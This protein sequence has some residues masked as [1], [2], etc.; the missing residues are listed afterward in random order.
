MATS[1]KRGFFRNVIES[2]VSARQRQTHRY[3]ADVLRSLD[4][5]S[6]ADEVRG[7]AAPKKRPD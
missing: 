1:E 6:L 7:S 5:E 3:L 2:F 4:R